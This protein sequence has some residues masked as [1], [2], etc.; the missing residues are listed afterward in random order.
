M[1]NIKIKAGKSANAAP[2]FAAALAL[3]C[4]LAL[5][6]AAWGVT[7][8]GRDPVAVI[9]LTSGEADRVVAIA[10]AGGSLVRSVG[11]SVTVALPGGPD[12]L[13]RLR[14]QGYWLVLDARAVPGCAVAALPV[15]GQDVQ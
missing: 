9:G 15:R 14:S 3:T 1:E 10:E 6:T 5:A 4:G 2:S 12:F 7:P 11:A 13:S 8:T